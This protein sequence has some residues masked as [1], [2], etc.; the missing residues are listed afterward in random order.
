MFLRETPSSPSDIGKMTECFWQ[1]VTSVAYEEVGGGRPPPAWKIQG[2]LC[3]HGNLKLLKN[4]G[5]WKIFQYSK[6]CKGN[7]DFQGKRRLFKILNDKKYIFNTVNSGHTL[8]FRASTSC[9]KIL[10]VNTIFNTMKDFRKNSVL[11]ASAS[12]S[13]IIISIQWKILG[14]TLFFRAS[15][16]CSKF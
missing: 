10:N 6:K 15:A 7:S 1:C 12:S 16:N 4:L 11:R 8:S 13:K 5:R 9:S 14:Q 3:F 2:K